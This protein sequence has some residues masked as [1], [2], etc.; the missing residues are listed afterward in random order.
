M[1]Q[2]YQYFFFMLSFYLE[3]ISVVSSEEFFRI[4]HERKQNT[5]VEKRSSRILIIDTDSAGSVTS[6]NSRRLLGQLSVPPFA[7]LNTSNT[8]YPD[9]AIRASGGTSLVALS[10]GFY[11]LL[12]SNLNPC[13]AE[14]GA[15]IS[16]T[17]PIIAL[18][19]NGNAIMS[20][21]ADLGYLFYSDQVKCWLP[22]V[23]RNT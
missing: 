22:Y 3:Y 8:I 15:S 21:R 7:Q 18:G 6:Y 4:R 11:C 17:D 10:V 19:F 1:T 5:L 13:F 12:N 16:I 14:K 9:L 23:I 2:S 20:A